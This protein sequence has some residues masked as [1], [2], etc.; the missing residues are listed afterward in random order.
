MT[1][2]IMIIEAPVVPTTD[3]SSAAISSSPA[4]TTGVP[5]ILPETRIPPAMVNRASRR[6]MKD[7]Y[8]SSSVCSTASTE[9]LQPNMNAMG[10]TTRAAQKA[11]NL[12]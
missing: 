2:R 1:G 6:M 11:A 5:W 12:P 4:L 3:A 10:I 8:S 7:M 9:T